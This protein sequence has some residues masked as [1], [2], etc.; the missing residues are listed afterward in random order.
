M[1]WKKLLQ[2]NTEKMP[3]K[4]V[5]F[6]LVLFG[7]L[8]LVIALPA[9]SGKKTA[10]TKKKTETTKA[11][12][13]KQEADEIDRN[14]DKEQLEQI[15]EKIDGVGRV[16]VMITYQDNG[17]QVVEKDTKSSSSQ[18][19][20][21]DDAG[22]K[23]TITASDGENTTVYDAANGDGEPFVSKNLTPKIEGI[24]VVAQ[25]GDKTSVRQNISNAI[26]ALFEI[27]PH[28]IVVVK[29]KD[30]EVGN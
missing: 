13:K 18:T 16:Q 28:K 8:M 2:K 3:D 11:Q 21:E 24:L 4:T 25:G 15:L 7:I 17:T 14:G 20:E 6:L 30:Q 27:E 12:A 22:G 9:G 5:F 26:L 19:T 23:R 29:M 1:D 10:D